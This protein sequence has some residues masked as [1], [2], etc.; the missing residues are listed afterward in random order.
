MAQHVCQGLLDDAVRGQVDDWRQLAR[1]AMCGESG[2]QPGLDHR[3]QQCGLF[4]EARRRRWRSGFATAEGVWRRVG[5]RSPTRRRLFA[6]HIEHRAQLSHGFMAGLTHCRHRLASLLRPA[7]HDVYRHPGL[8]VDDRDGVRE[9]VVLFASDPQ[10][11]F[12]HTALSLFL[13]RLLGEV[14][15]FRE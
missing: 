6:Q 5:R 14:R 7:V 4:R 3:G 12:G 9:Y 13:S 2:W 1:L 11:L 8:D 15:A 10:P